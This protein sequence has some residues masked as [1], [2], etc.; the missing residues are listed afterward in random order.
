[1]NILKRHFLILLLCGITCVSAAAQPARRL[2]EIPAYPGTVTFNESSGLSRLQPPFATWMLV[3]RTV[4]GSRLDKEK[5][6]AFYRSY[7]ESK[8]WKDDIFKRRGDEGY[9]GMRVDLAEDLDD[10]THIQL[11]GNFYMW[12]APQDGMYTV[13]LDQWRH[14]S[15]DQQTRNSLNKIVASLEGIVAKRDY[16]AQQSYSDGEWDKDYENEYLIERV[17]FSLFPDK[18][19]HE[20]LDTNKLITLIVLTY[21]DA[22]IADEEAKRLRLAAT[23][24]SENGMI[25]NLSINLVVVVV[26]NKT[27]LLLRD[28][29]NQQKDVVTGIAADLAKQ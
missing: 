16:R 2:F 27:V 15:V 19:T 25:L 7:L 9:L 8:G 12:V 5:V 3:Y 24:R 22:A 6:I 13:L 29:T 21:R 11:S 23:N 1:M 17:R 26:K 28:H 14:C 20:N 4:D 18:S 10:K